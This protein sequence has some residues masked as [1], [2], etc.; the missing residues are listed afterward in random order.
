MLKK[1]QSDKYFG[2]EVVSDN[3]LPDYLLIYSTMEFHL[4]PDDICFVCSL[5]C[6]LLHW[7]YNTCPI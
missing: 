3:E 2:T 4:M 1:T 7:P 5:R 6:V